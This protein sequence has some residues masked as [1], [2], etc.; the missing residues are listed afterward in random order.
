MS[1]CSTRDIANFSRKKKKEGKSIFE[2]FLHGGT[3]QDQSFQEKKEKKGSFF[4]IHSSKKERI[5]AFSFFSF[6]PFLFLSITE[7]FQKT[8]SLLA[9]DSETNEKDSVMESEE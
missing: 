7:R 5:N 6:F 1:F 4:S 2:F 8:N 3:V 9:C